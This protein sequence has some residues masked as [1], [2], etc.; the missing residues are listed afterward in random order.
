VTAIALRRDLR[1]RLRSSSGGTF[2]GRSAA[3][4]RVVIGADQLYVEPAGV[5]T[6]TAPPPLRGEVIAVWAAELASARRDARAAITCLRACREHRLDV[7]RV[8]ES[9]CHHDRRR[10]GVY[11]SHLEP[12]L[13]DHRHACVRVVELAPCPIIIG[14]ERGS[15]GSCGCRRGG[16]TWLRGVADPS[17]R[18]VEQLKR[19]VR[20]GRRPRCG[21]DGRSW[22]SRIARPSTVLS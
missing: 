5:P 3:L 4:D 10:V 2:G 11:D 20:P 16:G 6:R 7:R 21:T 12:L 18:P 17:T 1:T 15:R 22:T 13:G 9:P 19:V 8:R 14:P